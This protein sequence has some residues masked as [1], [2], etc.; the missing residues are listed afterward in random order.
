MDKFMC[1]P[2]ELWIPSL[3]ILIL[4]SLVRGRFF[5]PLPATGPRSGVAKIIGGVADLKQFQVF[6]SSCCTARVTMYIFGALH[7]G[8]IL[9]RPLGPPSLTEIHGQL[10]SHHFFLFRTFP[11][12][13]VWSSACWSR[14]NEIVTH[15]PAQR[16]N[17]FFG[18]TIFS[19]RGWQDG[20][21]GGCQSLRQASFQDCIC[22]K[23]SWNYL[24]KSG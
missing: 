4:A 8:S 21:E 3:I 13:P 16:I 11:G 14:R 12:S 20:P 2:L 5:G 24:E 23:K 15:S 17:G 7:T 18:W 22:P 10:Q 19:T 1:N 9:H 6:R